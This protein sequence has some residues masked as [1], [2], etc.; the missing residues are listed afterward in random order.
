MHVSHHFVSL[1]LISFQPKLECDD[2][3]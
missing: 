2:T 1:I 3:V